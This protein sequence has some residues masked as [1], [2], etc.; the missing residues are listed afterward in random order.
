MAAHKPLIVF[1]RVS[2]T[3]QMGTQSVHALDEVSFQLN[4]GTFVAMVGRSGSGKSTLLHMLGAMERPTQGNI[5]VGKWTLT[6]LDAKQQARYRREMVGM[7]FQ[8]FNLIPSMT[9]AENV[10]LPMT[11]A[12]VLPETRHARVAEVLEMVG[13]AHRMDHR[14][15]ELSGGEQQRVAISRALVNNPPVLLAD[16]P[17]GNLDSTTGTHIIDLL[18]RLHKD[19]GKTVVVVT[20]QPQELHGLA[21]RTFTLHDGRLKET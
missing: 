17:T 14:P 12:G 20:H 15:N 3:Y 6:D 21:E 2:K 10:A 7:I 19:L 13:L 18:A 8:K 4:A 9:A 11:L 5:R 16:E 1:D